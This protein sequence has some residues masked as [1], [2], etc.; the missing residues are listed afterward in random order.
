MRGGDGSEGL[1][2]DSLVGFS[3]SFGLGSSFFSSLGSSSFSSEG[4]SDE[5]AA[6]VSVELRMTAPI[7]TFPAFSRRELK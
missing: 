6:D 2:S 7:L 1:D 5:D 3:S 4:F